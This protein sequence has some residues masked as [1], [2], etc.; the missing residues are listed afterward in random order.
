MGFN[1]G[2]GSGNADL[3]ASWINDLCHIAKCGLPCIFSQAND[4]SD[5]AGEMAVLRHIVNAQYI[6]PPL[7]NPFS[8][9]TTAQQA[10]REVD[11]ICMVSACDSCFCTNIFF[12]AR[13]IYRWNA[14]P[15]EIRFFT[16]CKDIYQPRNI[17]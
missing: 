3:I 9:A 13:M 16:L 6:M 10:G 2:F 1:P 17:F 15:A 5:L 11:G 8:M 14:G 4:Y 7:R 12:F